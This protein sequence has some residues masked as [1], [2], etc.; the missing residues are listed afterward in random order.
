V[1]AEVTEYFSALF[2]GRHVASPDGPVDSGH[3][4][5]PDEA[6]FPPFW[7]AFLLCQRR[8]RK[9]WSSLSHLGS[10]RRLWKE[11]LLINL[12]GWMGCPMSSTRLPSQKL[13]L[14]FWMLSMRCLLKAS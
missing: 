7:R 8:T 3:T 9:H 11:L 13:A 5:Q 4:F 14:L 2:Q 6:F 12:Q 10:C 1:E